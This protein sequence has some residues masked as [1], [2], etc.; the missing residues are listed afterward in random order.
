LKFALEMLLNAEPEIK[1]VKSGAPDFQGLVDEVSGLKSQV[2]ILED[3][4]DVK[5]KNPLSRLLMS[6]PNLK[7]VVILSESNCIHVFRR[8]EFAIEKPSDL[9][10]VITSP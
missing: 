6:D 5:E 4:A 9:V 2:V 3:A 10:D 1:A 8:T 7:I